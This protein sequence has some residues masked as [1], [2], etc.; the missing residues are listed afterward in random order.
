[1]PAAK[2]AGDG[3]VLLCEQCGVEPSRSVY[4]G[5][6]PSDGKAARAAGMRSI[7]VLWGANGEET[8]RDHF[9]AIVVGAER[10]RTKFPSRRRL[11]RSCK[12]SDC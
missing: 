1:M 7:G 11:T 3:L 9:D 6:A 8:L 10:W 12:R 4:V 2:P 5:D